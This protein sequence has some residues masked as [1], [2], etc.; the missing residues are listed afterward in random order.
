MVVANVGHTP[1]ND[2]QWRDVRVDCDGEYRPDLDVIAK[3]MEIS[4]CLSTTRLQ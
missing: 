2:L 4:C 3:P 1:S